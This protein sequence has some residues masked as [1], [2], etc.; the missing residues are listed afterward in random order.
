MPTS[1]TTLFQKLKAICVPLLE[2]S[3]LQTGTPPK[4]AS[5][6]DELKTLLCNLS[7]RRAEL[8]EPL[9]KYILFALFAIP[10]QNPIESVPDHILE[11][12]LDATALLV[13]AYWWTMDHK[14]WQSFVTLCIRALPSADPQAKGKGRKRDE[15]TQLAAVR[16]LYELLRD[17][18]K[19]TEVSEEDKTIGAIQ[20]ALFAASSIPIMAEVSGALLMVV[21]SN[22]HKLQTTALNGLLAVVENFFREKYSPNV[23]PGIVS[24]LLPLLLKRQGKAHQQGDIVK[25][26]LQVMERVVILSV[27]DEICFREGALRRART[28]DDYAS[29]TQEGIGPSTFGG[30]LGSAIKRTPL[31]LNTASTQLHKAFGGFTLKLAGHPSP[32]ALQALIEFCRSVLLA[33]TEA[34]SQNLQI[35][36][37]PLV[38]LT[39]HDLPAIANLAHKAVLELTTH[40]KIGHHISQALSKIISD[41]LQSLP[42]LISG[43]NDQLVNGLKILI[44]A[45][46]ISSNNRYGSSST[47]SK[48]LGTTGGIEKWGWSILEVIELSTPNAFY[49]LPNQ[50]VPLLE[51]APS[52]RITFPQPVIKSIKDLDSQDFLSE[53]FRSWGFAAGEDALFAVEWFVGFA[54]KGSGAGEVSALWCASRLLEGASECRLDNAG[55]PNRQGVPNRRPRLER[56]ARWLTK[57]AASFWERDLEE[58]SGQEL[59]RESSGDT[60]Q[61]VEYVKGLNTLDELL[62]IGKNAKAS[63]AGNAL[64]SQKILYKAQALQLLAISSSVL[65]TRFATLLLQ[66]LYPPLHSFV[67]ANSFLSATAHSTLLYIARSCGFA[68]AS[69]LLLSNFDYALGSVSRYLTRQRLD[70]HAPRVL[71]VLVKLVGKGVV[72]RAADVVEECFERLDDYH[73]YRIV[74][75]GLVDVL[76]EVVRA[77]EREDEPARPRESKVDSLKRNR[78][79]KP[80]KDI[81]EFI[82]WLEEYR[83]PSVQQEKEDFGPAPRRAWGTSESEQN[84]AEQKQ[85]DDAP[86]LNPTQTLVQQIVKKSIYFLTHPSPF[87]RARILL[88]LTS[89]VSTLSTIESSLLPSVHAA[90][91]FILNRLNDS[92]PFVVVEAA[93]LIQ[94]LT[95]HVGE[96]MDLKIWDDVWPVFR[97][98]IAKLEKADKQSALA[99]RT[100]SHSLGTQSAYTTSHRLYSAV[101]KTMSRAIADVEVKD[102]VVWEVLLACRRFLGRDVHEEL[103]A[104]GRRLYLEMAVK[105]ADAVWLTLGGAGASG[106]DYLNLEHIRENAEM[107]VAEIE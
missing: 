65:E 95:E 93:E 43:H 76:L 88:V 99:R 39:L 63:N 34:L 54:S 62:A 35:L 97:N 105:N 77:V 87:I 16:C 22:N 56:H 7:D 41:T 75:E 67:S 8:D 81:R 44:A 107:I 106:P 58:E 74:V 30:E 47:I 53:L 3:R 79:Q 46:R 36:L 82:I 90:W 12:V 50:N 60:N 51:D 96:F 98:L 61:V 17:H 78:Q 91:P 71:V 10:R 23:L 18:T 89:S 28:L 33:C 26:C 45:A 64:E 86:K 6:L 40:P 32:M 15:E 13:T 52:E 68:S 100:A 94:A 4:L 5:H 25:H 85:E 55:E 11:R 31:W 1:T 83:R 21:A 102:S 59:P 49:A 84:E 92:E 20:L 2:N 14:T 104:L 73:G 57:L 69:N 38:L 48:I 70:M 37:L 19:D 66:A 80:E 24:T 42:Y 101:L 9:I 29:E 27:G 72:D 103:Q